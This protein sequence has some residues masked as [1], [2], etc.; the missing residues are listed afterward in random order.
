MIQ[1]K[2]TAGV[3]GRDVKQVEELK[4]SWIWRD[5]EVGRVWMREGKPEGAKENRPQDPA[6][7]FASDFHCSPGQFTKKGSLLPELCVY[8]LFT[9]DSSH[10]PCPLANPRRS[11]QT[12]ILRVLI[13]IKL[14]SDYFGL[15]TKNS[16]FNLKNTLDQGFIGQ[17]LHSAVR[18]ALIHSQCSFTGVDGNELAPLILQRQHES[19]MKADKA[20]LSLTNASTP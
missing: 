19:Q 2:I 1:P 5:V 10:G 8:W 18:V 4:P 3:Q 15:I 11:L 12:N 9:P 16:R 17:Q 13:T 6:R 20:I 14:L 7:M